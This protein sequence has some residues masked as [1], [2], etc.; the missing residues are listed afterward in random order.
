METL[1]GIIFGL[2][3]VIGI[4]FVTVVLFALGADLFMTM[5]NCV[6][7]VHQDNHGTAVKQFIKEEDGCVYYIDVWGRDSK[8][9]GSYVVEKYD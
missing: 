7:W 8:A 5:K 2:V 6:G 9:C 1:S 3:V 4:C